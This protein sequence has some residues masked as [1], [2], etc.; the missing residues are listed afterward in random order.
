MYR[1][2]VCNANTLTCS[3]LSDVYICRHYIRKPHKF[4]QPYVEPILSSTNITTRFDLTHSHRYIVTKYTTFYVVWVG[5]WGGGSVIIGGVIFCRHA[6]YGII[7]LQKILQWWLESNQ[8][9]RLYSSSDL[10]ATPQPLRLILARR[11]VRTKIPNV[12]FS[13]PSAK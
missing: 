11:L 3:R 5:A 10:A 6:Q 8:P 4:W 12:F 13:N 7:G 2:T 1:Y 9:Y